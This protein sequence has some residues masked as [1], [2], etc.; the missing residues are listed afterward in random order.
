MLAT[1]IAKLSGLTGVGRFSRMTHGLSSLRGAGRVSV[2]DVAFV[3]QL[4]YCC[5]VSGVFEVAKEE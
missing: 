1:T 5:G 3:P 4:G 2:G